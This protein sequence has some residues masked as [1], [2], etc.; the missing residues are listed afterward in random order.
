MLYHGEP[1]NI[2]EFFSTNDTA[3]TFPSIHIVLLS[4][5]IPITVASGEKSFLKLKLIRG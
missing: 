3:T 1:R 5:T 2:F 4:L